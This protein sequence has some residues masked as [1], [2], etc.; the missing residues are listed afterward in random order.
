MGRDRL[1]RL[2][3]S[4]LVLVL[5]LPQVSL[6]AQ[7]APGGKI[8]RSGP[9]YKWKDDKGRW[10]YSET[11]PQEQEF[12]TLE[13]NKNGR[14]VRQVELNRNPTRQ[15]TNEKTERER[16]EKHQAFL[17]RQRDE[18]LLKTYTDEREIDE[19]RDRN[20]SIPEQAIKGLEV[21]L[22]QSKESL[23]VLHKQA[24]E[25]GKRGE[26]RHAGLD[27]DIHEQKKDIARIERDVERYEKQIVAIRDKYEEDKRRFRELKGTTAAAPASAPALAQ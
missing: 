24:E 26:K 25:L 4:L 27:E 3:G 22:A 10:H 14:V 20:V 9:L 6:A 12:D 18:A 8:E 19:S 15:T 11:L 1:T 23:E 7:P 2:A 17:M 16:Q 13:L 5:Y 21:R